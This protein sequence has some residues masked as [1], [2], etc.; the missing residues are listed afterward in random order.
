MHWRPQ[1]LWR[2]PDFVKLWSGRTISEFGSRITR[3]GLPLTAALL[4]GAGPAQMALLAAMGAAPVLLVGLLA[5]VWVDRLPRRPILIAADLGQAALLLS[6]P[7]AALLGQLR[8]E[9]LYVVTALTGVL[10]VFFDVAD[11]SFLPAL[12]SR[13]HLVEGNSKL[14]TSGSLAE[15]GGP[16]LAGVLVQ[17]ITA[18]IAILLDALSFLVSAATVVAIRTPEPPVA[19]PEPQANWWREISLGLRVVLS[20]PTLR[21]LA[22]FSSLGSFFGGFYATL[23]VLYAIQVIGVTPAVLGILIA[24]GGVGAL[25]GAVVSAPLAR[26]FGLGPAMLLM[27]GLRAAVAFL[28]PLA[29]STPLALAIG[30]MFA[31]QIIGDF[32]AVAFSIHAVSLRQTIT[33]DHLLG[34]MNASMHFLAGGVHPFGILLGGALATIFGIQATLLIAAG[35]S[36]L[37][38]A[39]VVL[40][41]IPQMQT[42]AIPDPPAA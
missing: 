28:T 11:Q 12:V 35:G 7:I 29:A 32:A 26:R 34:R 16:V 25:I 24:G 39:W 23:Y 31:G 40:S 19:P 41:P 5:G 8:I 1:G 22:G 9:Q 36:V 10:K 18:P 27:A 6:I 15:I 2:H 21:A 13:E 17:T 4:L 38:A 37:A 20:H 42:T 33:P 14:E 30:L 3:E